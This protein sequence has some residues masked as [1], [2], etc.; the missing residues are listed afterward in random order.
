MTSILRVAAFSVP[1]DEGHLAA[2]SRKP[3]PDESLQAGRRHVA[4][5]AHRSSLDLKKESGEQLE[6]KSC[7]LRKF[8][9]AFGALWCV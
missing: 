5:G 1:E 3:R 7:D 9:F 6:A 2:G 4:C 8:F